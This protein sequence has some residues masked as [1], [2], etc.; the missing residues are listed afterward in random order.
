MLTIDQLNGVVNELTRLN[1]TLS[2]DIN[3]LRGDGGS[4][5]N[6]LIS[7]NQSAATSIC[8]LKNTLLSL[9][10]SNVSYDNSVLGLP[11]GTRC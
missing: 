4:A 11:S 6:T 1:R 3:G 10:D 8:S 7:A 5:A 9:V 2:D